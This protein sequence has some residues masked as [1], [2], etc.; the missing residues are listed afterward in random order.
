MFVACRDSAAEGKEAATSLGLGLPETMLVLSRKDSPELRT[1]DRYC[2]RA[3]QRSPFADSGRRGVLATP[4]AAAAGAGP[5]VP[6]RLESAALAS[7][8]SCGG[9]HVEGQTRGLSKRDSAVKSR[10]TGK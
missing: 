9:P 7:W 6:D 3:A 8:F 10:R 4:W 1:F 2:L 5:K